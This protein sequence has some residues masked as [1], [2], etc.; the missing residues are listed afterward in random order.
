MIKNS[1]RL[2]DGSYFLQSVQMFLQIFKD[3]FR[4]PFLNLNTAM[5]EVW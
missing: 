1:G 2:F 3:I 4:L 5:M